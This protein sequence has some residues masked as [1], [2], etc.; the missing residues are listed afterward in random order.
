VCYE[1]P[2]VLIDAGHLLTEDECERCLE[3]IRTVAAVPDV[4]PIVLA[5]T[6][7]TRF[8]MRAFRAGAGDFIDLE[9]ETDIHVTQVLQR[10]A[11]RYQER[12]HNRK[13]LL[14]LRKAMDELLK[15]LV[16][17]ERRSI[18]L[19]HQ[20]A[21]HEQ[22]L[23]PV[24]DFH[25]N[26][27]PTVLIIEDDREVADLLVEK[28]ER[29]GL[30]TFAFVTGEEAVASVN[31][32]AGR[33]E[34]IDLALVDARLPGMNGLE[35]IKLMRAAKPQLAAILMTGFSDSA[36]AI[37]AADLGVVG[38]VLKPFDDIP[39]LVRRVKERATHTMNSARERHYLEQIKQ[40]HE[41]VLLR[42]RRLAADLSN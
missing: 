42:Y 37:S 16:K 28:L 26:R 6:P 17:T 38:Y 27:Q 3:R 24:S 11:D 14:G 29:V 13:H 7:S 21:I 5:P 41:K 33:G 2:C 34:A 39:A 23:D 36:T 15:N 31:H 19:E 32:M 12:T 40:R 25:P 18:D 10:V 35:A 8:V 22:G 9:E 30:T 1:V 20:L 4:E